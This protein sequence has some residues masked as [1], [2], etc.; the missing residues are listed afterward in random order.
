MSHTPINSPCHKQRKLSTRS[1]RT[2]L[3]K[4]QTS[5]RDNFCLICGINFT[6]SGQGSFFNTTTTAGLKENVTVLPGESPEFSLSSRRVCKCCKRKVDSVIKRTSILEQDK[7]FL[8]NKYWRNNSTSARQCARETAE[9]SP[10]RYKQMCKESPLTENKQAKSR[11]AINKEKDGMEELGVYPLS[12]SLE[13]LES[14]EFVSHDHSYANKLISER[15]GSFAQ[16]TCEEE[17]PPEVKQPRQQIAA[18]K[19]DENCQTGVEQR[20]ESELRQTSSKEI[21]R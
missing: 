7:A 5:S 19:I 13:D 16:C 9:L 3:K 14:A 1:P 21:P 8:I 15:R 2:P 17:F 11:K 12:T 10:P 20:R 6:L 18:N 4:I